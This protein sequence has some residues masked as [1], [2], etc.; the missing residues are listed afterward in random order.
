MSALW[1]ILAQHPAAN[2]VGLV[3]VLLGATWPLFK[4][5]SGML[6]A[7]AALHVA[8]SLHFF[9]LGAMSGSL[10]NALG[11]GQ[12]LAAIP[13]GQRPGFRK[14]YIAY[15]PVIAAGAALT[16]QG[17]PSVFAA[18]GLALFSLARYQAG[19]MLL[20]VFMVAA[21]LSWAVHD[22]LV[23]SVPAL[24]TDALSLTTSLIMIFRER[25]MAKAA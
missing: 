19:T 6:W 22:Y 9:L 21:I 1:D 4:T 8:F 14:L 16:W 11:T 18:L 15:L 25:R 13:L 7:Q 2:L 23:M 17:A 20:R 12:V 10:M 5:R 3:A 24:C